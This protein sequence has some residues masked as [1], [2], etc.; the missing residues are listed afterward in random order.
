[1]ALLLGDF[2]LFLQCDYGNRPFLQPFSCEALD[3]SLYADL[4]RLIHTSLVRL[5]ALKGHLTSTSKLEIEGK[6]DISRY[7]RRCRGVD[8]IFAEL[9]AYDVHCYHIAADMK[10]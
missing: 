2:S 5:S 8:L 7:W 10:N 1:M 9:L 6:Q 4:G 3:A